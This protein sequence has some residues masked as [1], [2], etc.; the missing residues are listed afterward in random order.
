MTPI[1][2]GLQYV[3]HQ[4][5]QRRFMRLFKHNRLVMTLY[6]PV[7][8]SSLLVR[9]CLPTCFKLLL[10]G[11]LAELAVHQ[12]NRVGHHEIVVVNSLPRLQLIYFVGI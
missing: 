2:V 10:P 4:R 1:L 11:N 9:L 5:M 6:L 12:I 3:Y 8:A 7:Y